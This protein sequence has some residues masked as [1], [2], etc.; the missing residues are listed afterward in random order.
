MAAIL[1][2]HVTTAAIVDS[3]DGMLL[4]YMLGR[5]G[6]TILLLVQIVIMRIIIIIIVI[7]CLVVRGRSVG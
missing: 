4:I 3:L 7:H 6:W 2:C 1:Y 5:V